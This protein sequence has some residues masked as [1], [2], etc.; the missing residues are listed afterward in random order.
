MTSLSFDGYVRRNPRPFVGAGA[1]AAMILATA[2][3]AV[4]AAPAATA[5]VAD[6]TLSIAGGPTPDRITLR[7]NAL[8]QNRLEVDLG[9]DGSAE[10]TFDRSTFAA[11]SVAAGNGGDTVRV[12]Q[13]NGVFTTTEATRISGGNG[14]DALL[15]GSGAEVFDGGNGNDFVD[16]NAGA[17]SG[18]MG[19][20]DDVFVW[21]QGDGS[22]VVEGG[23]GADTMVFNG[24]G[25]NEVMSATASTGRVLFTRVQG[26]IVMNL[27]DV[28][29]IDVRPQGGTDTVTVNDVRGTDLR[30]VDVDLAAAPGISSGDGQADTVTVRGT[31]SDDAI[32]VRATGTAVEIGGLAAFVRITH[33]DAA[34][35]SLVI[36]T[37]AGADDVVLDP[38]LDGLILV[39]VQ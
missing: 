2:G 18:F 32:A 1:L 21:D 27:D 25:A 14:D 36:D 10:F 29:A 35:D 11:I 31:D 4:A 22:D 26:G 30:R 19:R 15:G 38:A 39:A 33:A 5:T 17:D 3:T 12:D 13:T 8:D 24:F 7:L 37:L 20:G 6:G 28:E 16:G 34:T 9:D 23:A